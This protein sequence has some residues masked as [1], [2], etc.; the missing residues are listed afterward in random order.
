MVHTAPA[1]FFFYAGVYAVFNHKI[2]LITVMSVVTILLLA[3]VISPKRLNKQHVARMQARRDERSTEQIKANLQRV[4]SLSRPKEL[5][6]MNFAQEFASPTPNF[7]KQK[8]LRY[9]DDQESLEQLTSVLILSEPRWVGVDLEH[10]KRH[11]YHGMVC[12]M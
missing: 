3:T 4:K 6:S 2:A 11:A 1:F 8:A 10:S 7:K 9:V 5:P 12:L